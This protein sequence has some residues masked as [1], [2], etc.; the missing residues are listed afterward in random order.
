MNEN[1]TVHPTIQATSQQIP[2]FC[3]CLG[4]TGKTCAQ[5]YALAKKEGNN[6]LLAI[7]H[8]KEIV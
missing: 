5:E 3:D 7:H 8:R 4:K 6:A 1:Q 2:N